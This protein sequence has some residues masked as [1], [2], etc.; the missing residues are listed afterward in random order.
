M[1][2]GQ[3]AEDRCSNVIRNE[4]TVQ[5]VSCLYNLYKFEK[6]CLVFL[7]YPGNI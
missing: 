6:L 3:K 4:G 5:V 7:I 2:L 1:A